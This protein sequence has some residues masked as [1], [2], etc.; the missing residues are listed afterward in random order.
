[1]KLCVLMKILFGFVGVVVLVY[2]GNFVYMKFSFCFVNFDFILS[3]D[4]CLFVIN[5]DFGVMVIVVN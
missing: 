1:M 3:G 5:K 2:G 4:V